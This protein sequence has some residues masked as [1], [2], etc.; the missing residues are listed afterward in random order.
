MEVSKIK[1]SLYP[2]IIWIVKSESYE[3]LNDNFIMADGSLIEYY[4]ERVYAECF[5]PVKRKG[6]DYVGVLM[7]YSDPNEVSNKTI[8][9]ESG[10]LG[11]L[12][13][14]E[15]GDESSNGLNEHYCYLIEYI[16]GE[17]EKIINK[18][19]KRCE[20]PLNP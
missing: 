8:C 11:S 6:S 4:P 5:A 16:F 19:K 9:H 1:I 2:R 17:I 20:K 14:R 7:A 18:D 12:L 15:L 3:E 10:H 13:L